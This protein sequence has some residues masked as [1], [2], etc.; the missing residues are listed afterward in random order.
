PPQKVSAQLR[1]IFA[2]AADATARSRQAKVAQTLRVRFPR[3]AALLEEEEQDVPAHIAFPQE[4]RRQLHSTNTLERL[5]KEIK[6]RTD[7][8]G[9]FPNQ[10]SL[11]RLVS[12]VL[13]E[14]QE[15]WRIQRRYFSGEA[16]LKPD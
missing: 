4:H 16:M 11:L 7:V 1:T 2:Q 10:T 12:A 3:A 15:E 5:N 6:R 14:A 8:V 9:I 13:E